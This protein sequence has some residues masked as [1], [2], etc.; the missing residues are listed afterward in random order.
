MISENAS[1]ISTNLH[2]CGVLYWSERYFSHEGKRIRPVVAL[3]LI[4]SHARHGL[5]RLA[6][7]NAVHG[8]RF[9]PRLG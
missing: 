5:V 1:A 9:S 2:V 8:R 7:I 3:N 4:A 6:D